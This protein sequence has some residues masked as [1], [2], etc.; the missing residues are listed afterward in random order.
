M[1]Q[2]I[3]NKQVNV[4]GTPRVMFALDSANGTEEE[5]YAYYDASFDTGRCVI[6]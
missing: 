4:T 6:I 2:V 5:T 3:Y 1:V